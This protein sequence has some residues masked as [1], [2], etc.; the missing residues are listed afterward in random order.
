MV[1]VVGVVHGYLGF[2]FVVEE[3]VIVELYHWFV[4]AKLPV[5]E[6]YLGLW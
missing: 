3:L 5:F 4:V 6:E 1:Q 2:Q